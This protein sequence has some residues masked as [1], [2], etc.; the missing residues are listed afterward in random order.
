MG[1]CTEQR[2]GQSNCMEAC[3]ATFYN[4]RTYHVDAFHRPPHT[5]AAVQRYE[6][7]ETHIDEIESRSSSESFYT[8]R[9]LD[10]RSNTIPLTEFAFQ[11]DGDHGVSNRSRSRSSLPSAAQSKNLLPPMPQQSTAAGTRIPTRVRSSRLPVVALFIAVALTALTIWAGSTAFPSAVIY[12]S[13]LFPFAPQ[14]AIVVIQLLATFSLMAIRECFLMS[15]EVVRWSY[16]T[17]GINFLS[18]IVLSEAT[19]F[20]GITRLLTT[21]HGQLFAPWRLLALFRLLILYVVLMFAQFVWLL[22]I[23]SRNTYDIHPTQESSGTN[24]LTDF[25]LRNGLPFPFSRLD[26]FG[27]LFDSSRVMETQPTLCSPVTDLFCAAYVYV[28]ELAYADPSQQL[29]FIDYDTPSYVVEFTSGSTLPAT[30]DDYSDPWAHCVNYTSSTGPSIR[31]CMGGDP[32]AST[33]DNWVV[34]AGWHFCYVSENCTEIGNQGPGNLIGTNVFTTTMYIRTARAMVIRAPTNLSIVD[35][36][37]IENKTNYP[38][39]ISDLFLA[40]TAPLMNLTGKFYFIDGVD[41]Y[42]PGTVQGDLYSP[43]QV[44]DRFVE[45]LVVAFTLRADYAAPYLRGFLTYALAANSYWDWQGLGPPPGNY[46]HYFTPAIQTY[47]L[48]ISSVSLIGFIVL[49]GLTIFIC[50]AM[51]IV[52]PR[53]P[54]PNILTFPEVMFGGRMDATLKGA[55]TGLSNGTS[56]MI[57]EK[58]VNV[59]IKVGEQYDDG[60]A[61]VV[62]ST[63]EVAPLRAN[64]DYI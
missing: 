23:S 56:N 39:N 25:K 27:T 50:A 54:S 63:G 46:V 9:S 34:N 7:M 1:P 55:L 45:S 10:P 35:I 43:S 20:W 60:V 8:T 14:N 48:T 32:R 3:G 19:G 51:L 6:P 17:K 22:N 38:V 52:F 28:G 18:F 62:I 47:S 33:V 2:A 13:K 57:I 5:P 16:A 29:Y 44:A 53:R 59:R 64:V 42:I 24:F 11:A 15:C 31:M 41:G 36:P 58:L 37:L 49:T 61:H 26:V 30:L 12:T 4:L 21:R 40:F